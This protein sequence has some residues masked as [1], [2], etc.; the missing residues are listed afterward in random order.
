MNS[1]PE[2]AANNLHSVLFAARQAIQHTGLNPHRYLLFE[3]EQIL[4]CPDAPLWIDSVAFKEAATLA[5]AG[6]DPAQYRTALKLYTGELLPEDR[7]EDWCSQPREAL[8][9]DALALWINLAKLR[10]NRQDYQ[11][12]VEA[13]QQALQLDFSNEP[14]HLGLMRVFALS[15]QRLKAL[16]QYQRLQKYLQSEFEVE[17]EPQTVELYHQILAQKI[18]AGKST[19]KEGRPSL[20]QTDQITFP[21]GIDSKPKVE[22]ESHGGPKGN[23]IHQLTRLIG[24]DAEITHVIA[25]VNHH[26]LVTLIGPGGMGKTRLAEQV[27]ENIN[28]NTSAETCVD[29]AWIID[30]A[31]VSHPDLL[32][33]VFAS[34]LELQGISGQMSPKLLA[35][36]IKLRQMILLFDNCE[37]IVEACSRLI[38]IIL[39]QCPKIKILVTSQVALQIPG[40]MVYVVPP[41]AVPD[42]N[43][44]LSLAEL[45]EVPSV[46]LLVDRTRFAPQPFNL[47]SA[48]AP[49]L[50][51][52]CQRLE[53]IP[54]A[55]ELAAARLNLLSIDQLDK[56]LSDQSLLVVLSQPGLDHG[57]DHN[58]QKTLKAVLEWSFGLL[59]KKEQVLFRRLAV[60]AGGFNAD[61]VEK[62]C[63]GNGW[64]NGWE[65][66]L[67]PDEI[68]D[69]LSNL[70]DHSMLVW[71][72]S[73]P[74][75]EKRF[76]MYQVVREYARF[77][78]KSAGEE[79]QAKTC[80]LNYYIL[81]SLQAQVNQ[82]AVELDNLRSALQYAFSNPNYVEAG[83]R[84][85]VGLGNFWKTHSNEGIAW[86][87][88][89]LNKVKDR[90]EIS[91]QVKTRALRLAGQL[92]S[93]IRNDQALERF[94]ES[95]MCLREPGLSE[96]TDWAASPIW[97][98]QAG[99]LM[100]FANLLQTDFDEFDQCLSY[101]NEAETL[102][103]ENDP[104]LLAEIHLSHYQLAMQQ[105]DYLQA[106]QRAERWEKYQEESKSLPG[107]AWCYVIFGELAMR[108]QKDYFLAGAFFEAG[109][110]VFHSRPFVFAILIRMA[111]LAQ[112]Q[113]NYSPQ[114]LSIIRQCCQIA[115]ENW[116]ETGNIARLRQTL[117]I[118]AIVESLSAQQRERIE[119]QFHTLTA[120]RFVG[121]IQFLNQL[122]GSTRLCS[123]PEDEKLILDGLNS[124]PD[125]QAVSAAFK[126]GELL[127]V[128]EIFTQLHEFTDIKI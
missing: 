62:I 27:A 79:E 36:C 107:I 26:R 121:A 125:A 22:S 50:S 49:A 98:D 24:R 104:A 28:Q 88:N 90:P 57:L 68:L 33:T 95:L 71:D 14:A 60:F 116:Q 1:D 20:N 41:L 19:L 81:W 45:L 9:Q 39:Y 69:T 128:S 30:L 110:E 118:L 70:S 61:T 84:L 31:A 78:L 127:S 86:L 3:N 17:P 16:R 101:L 93:G 106:C 73:S 32:P 58:H 100:D 12:A 80:S 67:Q 99:L 59:N 51:R 82:V 52:I 4:L 77:L 105:Q 55:L 64:E 103:F 92:L 97:K 46:K 109:L 72:A 8:Q 10:E 94:Q 122:T 65:N 111:Y 34:T 114:S 47:T 91:L 15:G 108:Y 119:R 11:A 120:A 102:A 2:D 37:H 53:G 85:C 126:Q 76:T 40:E 117:A 7:Y 75:T 43:Q 96:N 89:G 123:Y 29:G 21:Q 48:N 74:A 115:E 13:Y 56:R 25:L 38:Q 66:D 18:S 23:L 6:N 63:T 87:D 113:G 44:N 112:L 5:F 83:L 54:L 124:F 42:S 35:D